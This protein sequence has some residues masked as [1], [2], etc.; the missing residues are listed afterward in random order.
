MISPSVGQLADNV[1]EV[2]GEVLTTGMELAGD[3]AKHLPE[4]TESIGKIARSSA[5]VVADL[6]ATAIALT[7]FVRRSSSR[8]GRRW[9][10]VPAVV[11][12]LVAVL[13]VVKRSRS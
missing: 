12:A 2:V 5:E 7:P 10:V 11:V 6:A 1:T 3:A 9:W 13:A 4:V 8:R